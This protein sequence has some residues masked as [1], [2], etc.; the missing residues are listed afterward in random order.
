MHYILILVVTLTLSAVCWSD[1][2]RREVPNWA[3]LV[4][5]ICAVF[6]N[7]F[8]W[9]SAVWG[10][11]CPFLFL[12]PFWIAGG[13]GGGDL[14]MISALGAFGGGLAGLYIFIF[15]SVP[16][17]IVRLIQAVRSDKLAPFVKNTVFAFKMC[18]AKQFETAVELTSDE[19]IPLG[20]WLLPGFVIWEVMSFFVF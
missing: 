4:V 11:F 15:S 17:I 12:F 18:A 5:L 10:F 19:R 16:C 20:C 13:V 2:T 8:S 7:F 6:A 1:Y 14:K 9:K 3:V